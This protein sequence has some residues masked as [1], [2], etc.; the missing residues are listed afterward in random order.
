VA[1]G[2]VTLIILTFTGQWI[3]ERIFHIRI[4]EFQIASGIVLII[5]AVRN[6][7]LREHQDGSSRPHDIINLGVVPI[8][9][10]LLVGPG[11]IATGIL[12]LNSSSTWIAINQ[13]FLADLYVR[14]LIGKGKIWIK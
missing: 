4:S 9:V 3:M 2:Y 10:P 13:R 8:A 7:I 14:T 11:A 6:I 5:V 12:I 1:T